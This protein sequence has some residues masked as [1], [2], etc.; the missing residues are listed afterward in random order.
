MEEEPPLLPVP[1]EVGGLR[2][3]WDRTRCISG[4]RSQSEDELG[5]AVGSGLSGI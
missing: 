4:M 3:E 1:L 2:D 5:A